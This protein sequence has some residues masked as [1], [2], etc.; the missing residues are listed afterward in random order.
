M[1]NISGPKLAELERKVRAYEAHT[2]RE[3]IRWVGEKLGHNYAVLQAL[4]PWSKWLEW[5]KELLRETCK[6]APTAYVSYKELLP[7]E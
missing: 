6:G 3:S 1:P 2:E 4:K 7:K 5:E